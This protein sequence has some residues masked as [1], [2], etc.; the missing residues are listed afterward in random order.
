MN[1]EHLLAGDLLEAFLTLL[2]RYL[3]QLGNLLEIQPLDIG[4]NRATILESR[5]N[6]GHQRLIAFSAAR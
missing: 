2:K 5:D 1:V 4:I 6:M 3:T